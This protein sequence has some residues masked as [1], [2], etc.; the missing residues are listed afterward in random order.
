M[1]GC[2]VYSAQRVSRVCRVSLVVVVVVVVVV[3][4][5]A[6]WQQMNSESI[7]GSNSCA[8]RSKRVSVVVV[9]VIFLPLEMIL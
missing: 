9:K 6:W 3:V 7:S 5:A 1:C 4:A 8:C 2:A